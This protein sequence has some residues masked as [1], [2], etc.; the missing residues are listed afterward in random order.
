MKYGK[1]KEWYDG[2]SGEWVRPVGT[3]PTYEVSEEE[4]RFEHGRDA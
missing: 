4:R 3:R 2:T 1:T